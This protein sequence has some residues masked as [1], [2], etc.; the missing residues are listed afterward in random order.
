MKK[1]L[2]MSSLVFVAGSIAH[3]MPSPDYDIEKRCA[4]M[5]ER[6]SSYTAEAT[7]R[8]A[9]TKAKEELKY[10]DDPNDVRIMKKCNR[11]GGRQG[12]YVTFKMCVQQ[13]L[14]AKKKLEK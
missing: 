10:M 1:I 13:E 2:I 8:E 3:A 11:M 5:G 9:E 7:C 14:S 6:M 4:A 12:S